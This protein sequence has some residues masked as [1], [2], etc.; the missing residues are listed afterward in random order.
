MP[1]AEEGIAIVD[2][3]TA[4]RQSFER[5]LWAHDYATSAFTS[6]EDFLASSIRHRAAALILDMQLRGM[7][8]L[9]L[10]RYLLRVGSKIPIVFV[11]DNDD[12]ATRGEA[13]A[14]GCV[15]CLQKPCELSRLIPALDRAV[16]RRE[17][18]KSFAPPLL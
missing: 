10:G 5:L 4:V 11:T 2:D 6:A 13:L 15:D 12:E 17:R 7:S 18:R 14:L 16:Y 9:A 8:G 1:S 3:D